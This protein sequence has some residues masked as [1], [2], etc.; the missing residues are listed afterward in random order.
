MLPAGYSWLFAVG[1]LGGAGEPTSPC[2]LPRVLQ[3]LN[4]AAS[5]PGTQPGDFLGDSFRHEARPVFC[6]SI[7]LCIYKVD[8]FYFKFNNVQVSALLGGRCSLALCF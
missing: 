7:T 1:S 6:F 3:P 4:C 5:C 2:Q 8:L